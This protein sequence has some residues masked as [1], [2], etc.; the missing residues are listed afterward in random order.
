MG[1][2]I[3]AQIALS[4]VFVVAVGLAVSAIRAARPPGW[5]LAVAAVLG[6][7]LAHR[8]HAI[9]V[10]AL[11]PLAEVIYWFVGA[12]AW[13]YWPV[14]PLWTLGW[15]YVRDLCR[16]DRRP[17]A[18]EIRRAA[19]FSLG[20]ALFLFTYALVIHVML[21][22]SQL[23]D[24]ELVNRRLILFGLLAVTA[25][26][27]VIPWV[28][29]DRRLATGT[30]RHDSAWNVAARWLL[31]ASLVCAALAMVLLLVFVIRPPNINPSLA[32]L[33][34]KVLILLAYHGTQILGAS[35][36]AGS[37]AIQLFRGV[38]CLVRANEAIFAWC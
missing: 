13:E 10:E 4:L 8:F 24:L 34:A 20:S 27:V 35:L 14:L 38:I 36:F 12:V 23:P 28:H 33:Y 7:Y 29:I 22:R 21:Q 19:A 31:L 17:M 32:L 5:C 11:P 6:M 26:T 2:P 30:V 15:L 25:I 1:N 9:H 37:I 16:C 3:Q 18:A